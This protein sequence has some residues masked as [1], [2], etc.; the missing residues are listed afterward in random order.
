LGIGGKVKKN[1]KEVK[2]QE[3]EKGEEVKRED[4]DIVNGMDGL[5]IGKQI[6]KSHEDLV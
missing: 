4:A 6:I 1:K 3:E 2:D 5:K